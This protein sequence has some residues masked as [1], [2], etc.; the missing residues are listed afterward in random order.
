MHGAGRAVSEPQLQ[1]SIAGQSGESSLQRGLARLSDPQGGARGVGRTKP[2]PDHGFKS[3]AAPG[4]K[5]CGKTAR[6]IFCKGIP[7]RRGAENRQGDGAAVRQVRRDGKVYPDADDY[8]PGARFQQD[9]AELGTADQQV[10]GPLEQRQMWRRN[11]A[12]DDLVQGKSSQQRQ[13]GRRWIT[14]P[15]P[16]DG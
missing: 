8:R 7:V 10:V 15:G 12:R 6:Q 13:A 14:C 3:V 11:M 2:A 16:N 4:V 9:A 1:G 5:L